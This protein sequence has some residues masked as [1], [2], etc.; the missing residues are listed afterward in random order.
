RCAMLRC[1]GCIRLPPII[2][3]GTQSLALVEIDSAKLCFF[4]GKIRAIDLHFNYC[5]VSR[6]VVSATAGQGLS[7]SIPG[8]GK[9]LLGVFSVFRK[10]LS[11]SESEFY[12][13]QYMA[14]SLPLLH[15][16]YNTHG[17]KWVYVV[18]WHYVP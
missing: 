3:I 4:Y 18:Q 5:F 11:K 8:S 2:F 6:V 1:C 14:I 12:C 17:E 13:T 16:T 9:V 10:N 15:G 7:S